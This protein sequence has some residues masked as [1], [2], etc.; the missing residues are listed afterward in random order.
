PG[1]QGDLLEDVLGAKAVADDVLPF[2][3]SRHGVRVQSIAG[4]DAQPLVPDSQPS[5]IAHQDGDVVPVL[6]RRFHHLKADAPGRTDHCDVQRAFLL[7]PSAGAGAPQG[8]SPVT[9]AFATSRAVHLCF[10][11]RSELY[12]LLRSASPATLASRFALA[13][14]SSSPRRFLRRRSR[15]RGGETL[16]R[17][18][19]E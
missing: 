13:P 11:L 19:H 6:E 3:D 1:E 7:P 8:A 18:L 5:R 10:E 12:V 4:F 15:F 16:E 14:G 17:L 9:L 2:D